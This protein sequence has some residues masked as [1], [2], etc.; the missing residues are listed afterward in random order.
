MQH[1]IIDYEYNKNKRFLIEQETKIHYVENIKKHKDTI[2]KIKLMSISDFENNLIV[3]KKININTFLNL[4]AIKNLNVIFIKNKIYYELLST[5]DENIFII[6]NTK[7]NKNSSIYDKFGFNTC[8]KNDEKWK[9]ICAKYIQVNN[10]MSPI[11]SL[12]YYKLDDLVTMSNKFELPILY[13]G[14]AKKK[15]KSELYEQIIQYLS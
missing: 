4:C 12:S 7:H 14:T 8:Q 6:Y 5:D 3:E 10:I 15:K 13:E 9:Q 2:K 11:K 1:G